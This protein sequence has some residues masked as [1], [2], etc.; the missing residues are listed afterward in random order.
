[1]KP[2]ELFQLSHLAQ[3]LEEVS[4]IIGRYQEEAL[5]VIVENEHGNDHHRQLV[6]PLADPHEPTRDYFDSPDHRRDPS[7]AS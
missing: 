5:P 7:R 3:L 1:M 6:L 4:T 2:Y